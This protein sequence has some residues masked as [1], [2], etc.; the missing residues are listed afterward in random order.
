MRILRLLTFN[1][2]TKAYLRQ[3]D[4]IP[5]SNRRI[6]SMISDFIFILAMFFP[7][8]VVI[9]I[10]SMILTTNNLNQNTSMI[11]M[12]GLGLIPYSAMIFVILNKDFFKGQSISK[13]I[14]GYQ[15]IDIKAN[16]T[17]NETKCMLRNITMILWPLE[18]LM[19]LINPSRR[20]G[21]FIAGTKLIDKEKSEPE[22]ILK[23]FNQIDKDK[24]YLRLIWI[25]ILI[26]ILFDSF[27]IGLTVI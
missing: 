12:D 4:N 19:I 25:S 17:A 2:L 26:T 15:I 23:D 24:K 21:D 7:L 22:S 6:K 1:F 5:I 3:I 27:A 10:P 14:Y 11:L 8:F 9:M 20:L 18:A 13:R 16:Q